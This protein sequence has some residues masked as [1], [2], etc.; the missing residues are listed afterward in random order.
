MLALDLNYSCLLIPPSTNSERSELLSDRTVSEYNIHMLTFLWT[1]SYII[2]IETEAY[3]G[4]IAQWLTF[5]LLLEA[6]GSTHWLLLLWPQPPHHLLV[7]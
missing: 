3:I 4:Q 5:C 7:M 2:Q 6:A 1:E